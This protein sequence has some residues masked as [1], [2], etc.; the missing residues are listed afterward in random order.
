MLHS[1]SNGSFEKHASSQ[2]RLSHSV[3]SWNAASVHDLSESRKTYEIH[4]WSSTMFNIEPP[5][6]MAIA[7][8]NTA[9]LHRGFLNFPGRRIQIASTFGPP[10]SC[11]RRHW[12]DM[13]S[14]RLYSKSSPGFAEF[15]SFVASKNVQIVAEN[16]GRTIDEKSCNGSQ[17]P[18]IIRFYKLP[19][20][21][22]LECCL[23]SFRSDKKSAM[24]Q[25]A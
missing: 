8:L 9:F 10:V 25:S 24:S 13:I 17:N 14:R 22:C 11:D 7:C 15:C 20:R 19:W 18:R 16:D 3:R 1:I 5:K 12:L 6:R 4:P 21:R 2:N 23:S